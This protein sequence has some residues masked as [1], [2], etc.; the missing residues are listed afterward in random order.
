MPEYLLTPQVEQSK[1]RDCS[2][3]SYYGG[4]RE[5][6]PTESWGRDVDVMF[7]AEAPG[8]NEH[9]Q[10]RPVVGLTGQLL[11]RAVCAINGSE[12]RVAYG[13]AVRCRPPDNK[14][15]PV[16]DAVTECR[17]NI[18]ADIDRIK[19]RQIVLCG[20]P[21]SRS[22]AHYPES[23][24]PVDA[25]ETLSGLRGMDY[26][27]KTPKG[28]YPA[29]VT[30]HPSAVNRQPGLGAIFHED[31]ERAFLRS[32]DDFDFS[33]RG[34]P[35][36]II[37]TVDE[38]HDFLQHMVKNLDK[39]DV[40]CLDYETETNKRMHNRIL[41][42]G[43]AYGP[44]RGVVIPYRH[45]ESPFTGKELKEVR[46]LIAKF[47]TTENVSFGTLTAHNTVFEAH[48][49]ENEFG[50]KLDYFP[51]EDTMLRAHGIAENRKSITYRSPSWRRGKKPSPFSLKVLADEWLGFFHYHDP[52]IKPIV[53]LRNEGRLM[54]APLKGL[55]EYNGMDCYVGVRLYQ[56]QEILARQ[57]NYLEELTRLGRNHHGP[58][59]I[60]V[61]HLERSGMRVDKEQLRYLISDDSKVIVRMNEIEDR[62]RHMDTVQEANDILIAG[63]REKRRSVDSGSPKMKSIWGTTRKGPWLFHPE[64]RESH[65]ALFLDV[66]ELKTKAYTKK[67]R[68]PKFD[69]EFLKNNLGTPEVALIQ[70]WKQLRHLRSNF[71]DKIYTMVQ[72]D[73]DMKDG[74]VRG[75]FKLSGTATGRLSAA[76]P[77]LQQVPGK[78]SKAS[79]EIKRLYICD[80]GN[81]MVCADYS[82]AEVRW[83]SQITGDEK[84]INAYSKALDIRKRYL[85]NP[86][87]ELR[88]KAKYG[89]GDFH[90][91]TASQIFQKPIDKV[92]NE[93]RGKSKAIVFG[94]V[95]GMSSY[96]LAMRLGIT[97]KEAED[98]MEMFFKQFPGAEEWLEWI[99]NDG[100]ERGYVESPIGRRR[101][102]ASHF[103][104]TEKSGTRLVRYKDN[105]TDTWMDKEVATDIGKYRSYEDRICRNSPIQSIASDM[106][107]R[108]C[109]NLIRYADDHELDWRLVNIVHDSIIAEVPFSDVEHYCKAAREIMTDP[110]IFSDFGVKLKV[111]FVADFSIGVNWGDQINLDPLSEF[112]LVCKMRDCGVSRA[113]ESYKPKNRRCEKCSARG[114]DVFVRLTEGSLSTALSYLDHNHDLSNHCR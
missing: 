113:V 36:R 68:L 99:E 27:V 73:P 55:C 101:H 46:G 29:I 41:T 51:I 79:A 20:L 109:Y 83:L 103:M 32:Q 107:L 14:L 89:G 88:H 48:A 25:A 38:V 37:E 58:G 31:I 45:P 44:N 61:T 105:R 110:E 77:N 62:L 98:Y 50:V 39:S 13:N 70:E 53:D 112:E 97:K 81:V 114:E 5:Q 3:C 100:F 47:F 86:T 1:C 78:Y 72:N 10:K 94:L 19:P 11:R 111:P 85:A 40:V 102:M 30:Y 6:V 2:L 71:L 4:N 54:E 21:S 52:D 80:P 92:T 74:R 108:A 67:T 49:T 91:Q 76:E 28:E 65:A 23:G 42:V 95:Y 9:R 34:K 43:F 60:V 104:W 87:S 22:L 69:K 59:T 17:P 90:R 16:K 7:I 26:L 84:L 15:D 96:G 66:L 64:K 35:V 8:E 56:Y 57:H 63:Q 75:F 18:L 82:Q 12:E 33:S 93:E 24:E 106:N